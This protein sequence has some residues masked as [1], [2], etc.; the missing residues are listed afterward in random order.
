M[1]F[2]YKFIA[3]LTD[4]QIWS[5]SY[6]DLNFFMIVKNLLHSFPALL[7]LFI[8]GYIL[9]SKFIKFFSLSAFLHAL[10]DFPLHVD[11]G[12]MQFYP[13]SKW[14]YSSSVSYW[15]PNHYGYIIFPL[16]ALFYI[17]SAIYLW[18]SFSLL[19]RSLILIG[20]F[21]YLIPLA[22]TLWSFI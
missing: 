2:F 8:I 4:Q 5:E 13:F 21:I 3:G 20:G 19:G 17:L 10:L 15:D 22:Y 9:K 12:H 14:I 1:Y 7:I 6:Y 18:K 11:D 16:E